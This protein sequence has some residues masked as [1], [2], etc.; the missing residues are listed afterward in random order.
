[1]KV[2][3]GGGVRPREGY[4]NCDLLAVPGVDHVLD[5]ERLGVN[6]V[7]LPFPDDSVDE[8]YSSHCLEH[9]KN[10]P[11]VL[12]EIARVCKLGAAVEIRVPHFLSQLAMCAGH[13]H[14][15]SELQI[16]NWCV[17]FVDEWWA[18]NS[19][20]LRWLSSE[21]I[22]W[23]ERYDRAAILFPT[24]SEKDIMDFIPGCCHEVRFHFDVIE[25]PLPS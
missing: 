5:F 7:R 21:Q 16:Q 20:R 13:R 12:R 17:D 9:V 8:L 18:G 10:I 4:V 25:S 1:M 2:E 19:K 6:G 14:V 22:R 15:V 23:A 3:L 24:W 11:G